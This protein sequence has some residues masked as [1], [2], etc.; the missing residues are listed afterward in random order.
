MNLFSNSSCKLEATRNNLEATQNNKDI[1]TLTELID[2]GADVNAQDTD[3]K[4]VLMLIISSQKLSSKERLEFVNALLE[5]G[6]DVSITDNKDRTALWWATY[7]QHLS[8]Q[9]ALEDAQNKDG[10]TALTSALTSATERNGYNK[11]VEVLKK[12]LN[13]N[14]L[15][16]TRNNKDIK[17]LIE[18]IDKGADINAQDTDGKTVLMLIIS[19]QKLSSKKRLEFVNALLEKGA[20]LSIKDNEGRTALWW[21]TY[22]TTLEVWNALLDHGADVHARDNKGN[23]LLMIAL[24]PLP[25]DKEKEERLEI[26]NTLIEKEVDINAQN[27]EGKTALM[28]AVNNFYDV[29]D[30]ETLIRNGANVNLQDKSGNTAL[31]KATTTGQLELVNILIENGANVY[32][33]NNGGNYAFMMTRGNLKIKF[34]LQKAKVRY[35]CRQVFKGL[36]F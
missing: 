7:Y 36:G 12:Q 15:E 18:L 17:T 19:S 32:I 1:K 33:E 5:K 10:D 8:I 20:D 14:L 11:I 25:T 35:V 23:T 2:K 4:T 26:I 31:M 30:V 13:D 6:A 16:A 24:H 28:W 29:K 9:E 3:G 22:Y 21:A 34:A 27:D